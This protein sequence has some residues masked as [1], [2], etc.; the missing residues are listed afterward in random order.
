MVIS[1]LGMV[2]SIWSLLKL[3]KRETVRGEREKE[4]WAAIS[5]KVDRQTL[6]I[7]YRQLSELYFD[8]I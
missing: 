4:M 2:Y 6:K 7:I 3:K 1:W 8:L 5:D